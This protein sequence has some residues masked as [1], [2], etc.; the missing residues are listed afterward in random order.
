MRQAWWSRLSFPKPRPTRRSGDYT[1]GSCRFPCCACWPQCTAFPDCT[2]ACP[3]TVSCRSLH[4]P[5]WPQPIFFCQASD[6]CALNVRPFPRASRSVHRF[7][8]SVHREIVPLLVSSAVAPSVGK[9]MEWLLLALALP[10]HTAASTYCAQ[11][12]TGDRFSMHKH[13]R[14]AS[15]EP[16]DRTPQ[17][18]SHHKA[19]Q[20]GRNQPETPRATNMSLVA[21]STW[22]RTTNARTRMQI[23]CPGL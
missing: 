18:N 19:V 1:R 17:N 16:W 10:V 4:Q 14:V 7:V 13:W 23:K 2:L 21:N 5:G 12:P 8:G 20:I 15:R 3:C 22:W 6:L 9:R 11:N